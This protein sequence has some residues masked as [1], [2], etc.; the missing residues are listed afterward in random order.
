MKEKEIV[1]FEA[2]DS[3]IQA[4]LAKTKLDA[5]GIP[6]FLSDENFVSL[7]PI[8]NEIFP[9]I[10]LHIFK[11][12]TERVREVLEDS[13]TGKEDSIICPRCKSTDVHISE[14]K[15]GFLTWLIL[16]FSASAIPQHRVFICKS[17]ENEFNY[18]DT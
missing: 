9:G 12:D 14:S 4:N 17:C 1:V 5:Y 8:R 6:C 15:K 18:S 10:R 7:Y 3:L 2:Y 16:L 13:Q 11:T